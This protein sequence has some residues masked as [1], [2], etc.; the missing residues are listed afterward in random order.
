M[1]WVRSAGSGRW[2]GMA[3]GTIVALALAPAAFG[4]AAKKKTAAPAAAP[5]TTT[6]ERIRSTGTLK[7]GYRTDAR[8]FS[9]K[10]ASGNPTGYSVDLCQGLQESVK[11]ELNI[12][13]LKVEWVPV[14]VDERLSAIQEHQVDVLCG[15]MSIT[16]GRRKQVDFSVPIFPGGVGVVVRKDANRQLRNILAGQA[17][18]YTPDLAGRGPQ[19][20]ARAGLR[21]APWHDGRAVAQAAGPG[22]PDPGRPS[23]PSP[24]TRR[25]SRR[26]WTER[27]VPS[28]GNAPF[29][30]MPFGPTPPGAI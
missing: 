25:A 28:S 17:K 12:P 10:D 1:Q 23:S 5:P 14:Q 3:I 20:R 6:V 16:L 15:A 8:P 27:S 19:H 22:A 2:G 4:Q 18:D 7:L 13:S 21:D 26:F 30:W 11:S 29:S 9:F 24:A